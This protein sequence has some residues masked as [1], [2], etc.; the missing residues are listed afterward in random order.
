MASLD[1][2]IEKFGIEPNQLAAEHAASLGVR[3]IGGDLMDDFSVYTHHFGAIVLMDV[4]EHVEDPA[5]VLSKFS[6]LLAPDGIFIV[7]TGDSTAWWVRRALP[8]YW[9]MAYPIHLVYLS[10][11]YMKWLESKG[12]FVRLDWRL[13]SHK[14]AGYKERIKE[15]SKAYFFAFWHG[16]LKESR[17]E[18]LVGSV[19]PFNNIRRYS[20]PPL[21]MTMLDHFW[22]VLKLKPR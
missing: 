4:I 5:A 13:L 12:G 18:R 20:E 19:W 21:L 14:K 2:K 7:L 16:W 17:F 11:R 22:T 9:Y 3:I 10:D 8:H 1:E 6:S 15:F